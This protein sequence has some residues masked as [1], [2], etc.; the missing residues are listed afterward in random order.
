MAKRDGLIS[1]LPKLGCTSKPILKNQDWA[2]G[3][4]AGQRYIFITWGGTNNIV[5]KKYFPNIC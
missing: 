4:L 2:G 5:F 3:L 1:K